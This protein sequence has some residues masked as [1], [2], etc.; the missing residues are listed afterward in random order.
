MKRYILGLVVAILSSG[1][2]LAVVVVFLNPYTSEWLGI[3]LL[4]TSIFFL[5]SSIFTLIGFV[6]RVARSRKEVIF[7]H[8]STS[9]RQ[10][11]LLGLIVV[12]SLL[13][14]VFRIFNIWS[15]LLFVA[16]V[17]LIELAFQSHTSTMEIRNSQRLP[18]TRPE[19][20]NRL[21]DISS[22]TKPEPWQNR[23]P[24]KK[25]SKT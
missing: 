21:S 4:L 14:Q 23:F 18:D 25:Q 13:L 2:A 9:F 10:G 24:E 8:L 6:I 11:L 1:A 17:V 5:I 7:A 16:A 15:A 22:K 20:N 12:G 3:A 19:P